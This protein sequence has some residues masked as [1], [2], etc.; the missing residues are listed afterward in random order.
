MGEKGTIGLQC[1]KIVYLP[2]LQKYRKNPDTFLDQDLQEEDDLLRELREE[3]STRGSVGPYYMSTMPL[4]ATPLANQTAKYC[5]YIPDTYVD[6]YRSTSKTHHI[7]LAPIFFPNG[8]RVEPDEFL[9]R[10]DNALLEIMFTLRHYYYPATKKSNTTSKGWFNN[11]TASNTYTA[12][13]EQIK[14]LHINP[15]I[16]SPIREPTMK[17]IQHTPPSQKGKGSTDQT[18]KRITL[19]PPTDGSP[20]NLK[21]KRVEGIRYPFL[22][23]HHINLPSLVDQLYSRRPFSFYFQGQKI[24]INITH[25]Q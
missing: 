3:H 8:K 2:C 6:A 9:I 5:S 4:I 24:T 21:K 13:I 18:R 25:R 16:R 1:F 19:L 23:M 17:S 14:I 15:V 10:L 20:S 22:I 11:R 12:T 7:C